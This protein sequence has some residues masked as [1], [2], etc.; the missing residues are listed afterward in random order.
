[1][2]QDL[3]E[4]QEFSFK[5]F[6]IPFTTI[7]AIHWIVII[8]FLVYGNMLFNGFVWED[9][10]LIVTNPAGHSFDIFSSQNLF[11]YDGSGQFRPVSALASAILHVVFGENVFFYHLFS[12]G[13]HVSNAVLVFFI[14]KKFLSKKISFISSLFFL[15]HPIQVES[16][17]Y[18]ASYANLLFFFFGSIALLLSTSIKISYKRFCSIILFLLLSYF[19]KETGVLFIITATV[20]FFLFQK[21]SFIYVGF[22]ACLSLLLISIR[23]IAGAGI[24]KLLLVPIAQLSFVERLTNVPAIIFYY[25][26]T[27]FLPF[28]LAINQ[29]WIIS[30]L[31]FSAF[32]FPLIILILLFI[33]I[34]VFGKF[35]L[36]KEQ[37]IFRIF[38]FFTIWF[39]FGLGM[40]IQ[41]IPLNMTVADH[42]FYFPIAGLIGMFGV[43]AEEFISSKKYVAKILFIVSVAVLL[44]FS[45]RTIVRNNNYYDDVA[46]FSHDSVIHTNAL[47]EFYF[48]NGYFLQKRYSDALPYYKKSME[49]YPYQLNTY[50]IGRMY[51]LMGDGENAKKYYKKVLAYPRTGKFDNAVRLSYENTA[52]INTF[53]K[54]QKREE[55]IIFIYDALK[56]YP[57][58]VPL[59]GNLAINEYQLGHQ[60]AALRAAEKAHTLNPSP[61]TEYIYNRIQH[62]KQLELK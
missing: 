11:N 12:L 43:I 34:F 9:T 55:T 62:K 41:L 36:K 24:S 47:T 17:A 1:M 8:G 30:S 15:V 37:N 4:V 21:K 28:R 13:L 50:Q 57:N 53:V 5:S 49:M 23:I 54:T 46:L 61:K 31:S 32:Y 35:V 27:F 26:S 10:L 39:L 22:F 33:G 40:H 42:W 59:W 20:Y 6:F 7:K 29:Q 60:E 52:T 48:A 14:F 58:S 16:V 56:Q 19:S 38:L 3:D 51:E 45:L 18:F 44:I 2:Y 25:L